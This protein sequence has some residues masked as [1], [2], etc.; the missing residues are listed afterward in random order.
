MKPIPKDE[1]E[2]C[3]HCLN[4]GWYEITITGSGVGYDE[5]G[6]PMQISVPELS[7]KQCEFCYTNPKSVF[8]QSGLK[9]K[10]EMRTEE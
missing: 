8:I 4:Q 6:E 3:P 10:I 1:W 9:K 7:Q 2:D 5:N